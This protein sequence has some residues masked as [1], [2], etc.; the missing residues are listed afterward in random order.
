MDA[1]ASSTGI[2]WLF[3]ILFGLPAAL[4]V[5]AVLLW[6]YK[7]NQR[8]SLIFYVSAA[9]LTAFLGINNFNN[10]LLNL[11]WSTDGFWLCFGGAYNDCC[12]FYS[13][14]MQCLFISEA[15]KNKHCPAIYRFYIG[16]HR[17]VLYHK[18]SEYEIVI[19]QPVGFQS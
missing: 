14:H 18:N 6:K 12:F 4:S 11:P 10:T 13:A 5:L 7:N 15:E 1:I 19:V 17:M 16:S 8:L 2:L 9:V 3:G